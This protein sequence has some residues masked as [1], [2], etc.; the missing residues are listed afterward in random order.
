MIELQKR[1][2]VFQRRLPVIVID[3][4][5]D[6][7][8]SKATLWLIEHLG[9]D[10]YLELCGKINKSIDEDDPKPWVVVEQNSLHYYLYSTFDDVLKDYC[11]LFM[12]GKEDKS[13]FPY[14]FAHWCSF[15][16]CALNLGLWKPKYLFHD[17]EKPWLK[18]F[19]PYKKVQKW[20]RE[21]NK[22]HLEYG[23]KHGWDKVDWYAL[24]IDWEC[25]HMSKKQCP[26]NAREEMENKLSDPKWWPYENEI[27]TYLGSLLNA[28]FM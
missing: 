10:E 23:L 18:L 21:H 6:P 3:M 28:Y 1:Y 8:S 2:S 13:S 4:W 9:K 15:Q 17:F 20:H 7:D 19:W 26:L 27:K 22:H 12:F 5:S 14:W 11:N 16:V 24:M 25:S